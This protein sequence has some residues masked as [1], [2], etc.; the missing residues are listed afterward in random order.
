MTWSLYSL[1]S[2]QEK[3]KQKKSMCP[4]ND[5]YISFHKIL[6][7]IAPNWKQL[8]YHSRSECINKLWNICTIEYCSAIEWNELLVLI[9]TWMNPSVVTL[10]K[11]ARKNI[12]FHFYKILGDTIFFLVIENRSVIV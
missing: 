4:S 5:L 8:Q 6:F 2:I 10:N 7:I 9:K 3:T 1:A 11:K 12:S